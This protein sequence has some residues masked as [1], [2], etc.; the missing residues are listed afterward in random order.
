MCAALALV[1]S[2]NTYGEGAAGAFTSIAKASGLAITTTQFFRPGATDFL[3]IQRALLDSRSLVIVLFAQP[4]DGSR[5]LRS[6]FELGLGG[7]DYLF[8]GGDT[9]ATDKQ[10]QSACP[11]VPTHCDGGEVGLGMA[12]LAGPCRRREHK[13]QIRCRGCHVLVHARAPEERRSSRSAEHGLIRSGIG[14][15]INEPK[16][17]EAKVQHATR[18]ACACPA[19][20]DAAGEH[21]LQC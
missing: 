13:L 8:F 12:H 7:E 1:H 5:F 4:L 16:V 18:H 10:R 11:S 2:A 20:S 19:Q 3:T 14:G 6:S 17:P 9:M 15:G 21:V